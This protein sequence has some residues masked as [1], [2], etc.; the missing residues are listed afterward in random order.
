MATFLNGGGGD[1]L[2]AAVD[3]VWDGK[4]GA[5]EV[6]REETGRGKKGERWRGRIGAC[7][8]AGSAL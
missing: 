6:V 4:Q 8:V 1:M 7:F 2:P 5:E 3:R